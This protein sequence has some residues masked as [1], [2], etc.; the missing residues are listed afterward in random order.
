MLMA[1][2]R[3]YFLNESVIRGHHVYKYIWTPGVNK[4]LSVEKEPRNLHDNFALSMVKDEPYA[5]AR[6]QH[7]TRLWRSFENWRLLLYRT[8]DPWC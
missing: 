2:E 4:A 7:S 1:D 8:C 5:N 6:S 3:S